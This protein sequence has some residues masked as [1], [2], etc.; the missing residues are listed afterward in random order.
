MSLS[1]ELEQA[2]GVGEMFE[3]VKDAV[4]NSL[5]RERAGLMLGLSSMGFADDG[6]VG[7][8]HPVGSNVIVM[9]RSVLERIAAADPAMVKPYTFHIL[10]HEYLHALGVLDEARTRAL[11][12]SVCRDNFG[13]DHAVTML[14]RDFDSL[15]RNLLGRDERD[16]IRRP[17][18]KE[19]NPF[20]VTL[21]EGFEK[22]TS[23]IG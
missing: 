8:Y 18:P 7:A 4:R 21:V 5:S 12:Y 2:D 19:P 10:L 14:A 17:F 16:P 11:T 20:E 15:L 22:D 1:D 23:Y 3:V 13:E 9:N 6:F